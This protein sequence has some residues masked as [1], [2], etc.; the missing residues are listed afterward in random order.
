[1]TLVAEANKLDFT[2]ATFKIKKEYDQKLRMFNEMNQLEENRKIAQSHFKLLAN[3]EQHLEHSIAAL[4]LLVQIESISNKINWSKFY[5]VNLNY[6][7]LQVKRLINCSLSNYFKVYKRVQ[8]VVSQ[9]LHQDWWRRDRDQIEQIDFE[10]W[11]ICCI[12]K[13]L[14][15]HASRRRAGFVQNNVHYLISHLVVLLFAQLLFQ[16]SNL[17]VLL[18]Q[19]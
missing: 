2:T 9:R 17:F 18:Y 3:Q 10:M 7:D 11:Q 1:M 6:W 15:F 4:A 12:T 19:Q 8:W 16:S 14:K 5:F 13:I